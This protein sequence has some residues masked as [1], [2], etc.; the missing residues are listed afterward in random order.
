MSRGKPISAQHQAVVTAAVM[1]VL[2]PHAV[3]RDIVEKHSG[4]SLRVRVTAIHFGI[5]TFWNRWTER[6]SQREV[7]QTDE[8]QD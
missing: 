6:V 1:A 7:L 8:T 2:G 4:P 5:R 3:V